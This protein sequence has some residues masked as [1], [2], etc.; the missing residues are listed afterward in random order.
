MVNKLIYAGIYLIFGAALVV[1]TLAAGR[2]ASK[3]TYAD[4]YYVLIS[5]ILVA[6]MTFYALS[7]ILRPRRR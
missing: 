2:Y 7:G 4:T 1:V 3:G 5:G 6:G